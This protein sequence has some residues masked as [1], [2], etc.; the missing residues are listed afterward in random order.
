MAWDYELLMKCKY[1]L[2]PYVLKI[3]VQDGDNSFILC[4][5]QYIHIAKVRREF[6]TPLSRNDNVS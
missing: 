6:E 2:L 1:Y 3:S 5:S 4:G